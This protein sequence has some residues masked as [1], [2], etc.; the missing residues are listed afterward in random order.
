MSLP[1]SQITS[2]ALQKLAYIKDKNNDGVLQEDEFKNFKSDAAKRKDISDEDFNQAMGLYITKPEN[3]ELPK[4]DVTKPQ[5]K[6]EE[7]V[8]ETNDEEVVEECMP[9]AES[10]T[11]DGKTTY[12]IK[13]GDSWAS[14]AEKFG[15]ITKKVPTKRSFTRTIKEA[16]GYGS[17]LNAAEMPKEIRIDKEAAGT[18][19][20]LN[21][22]EM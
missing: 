20:K 1:I 4:V 7:V 9:V 6:K 18:G 8:L 16:V 13:L 21:P 15:F 3:N 19:S 17:K 11:S 12:K 22:N 2:A 14:L 10:V 5:A